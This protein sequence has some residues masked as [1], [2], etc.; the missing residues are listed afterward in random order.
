M[1]RRYIGLDDS[2]VILRWR[3]QEL[4]TWKGLAVWWKIVKSENDVRKQY[5]RYSKRLLY[6][7]TS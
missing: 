4:D 3:N 7:S 1:N 6:L 2:F 5:A